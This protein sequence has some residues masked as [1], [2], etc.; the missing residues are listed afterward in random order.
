MT[1]KLANLAQIKRSLRKGGIARHVLVGT[2][3]GGS[4][5]ALGT[6]YQ[7]RR[8]QKD[9]ALDLDPAKLALMS[10]IEGAFV[11]ASGASSIHYAN[12]LVKTLRR[13]YPGGFSKRAVSPDAIGAGIGALALGTLGA[14]RGATPAPN[15]SLKT[16]KYSTQ[17]G[18]L[19]RSIKGA[20]GG[21]VLGAYTGALF[22]SGRERIHSVYNH[23]RRIPG[24][25][26]AQAIRGH[27]KILKDL[28][29]PQ[30]FKTKVEAKAHYRNMMSKY[31]PDKN[32]E[33]N[34]E[35]AMKINKAWDD[36]QKTEYFEKLAHLFLLKRKGLGRA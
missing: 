2:A 5:P 30:R 31:H 19:W 1:A 20:V 26:P 33:V 22:P 29:A 4:V 35:T 13:K 24:A 8:A 9:G 17:K 27:R 16:G 6:Y 14:I 7:T 15:Y 25:A 28:E 21:A 11:G 10:G 34:P 3:L 23:L 32:P 18:S 36:L 12:R